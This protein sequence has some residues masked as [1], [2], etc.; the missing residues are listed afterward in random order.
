MVPTGYFFAAM[1]K[2]SVVPGGG[3]QQRSGRILLDRAGIP[4]AGFPRAG[5]LWIGLILATAIALPAAPKATRVKAAVDSPIPATAITTSASAPAR[6]DTT[7]MRKLYLEGDFDQAILILEAVL[8][9]AS[10]LS[11]QD[12]VFIFKHLGVMYAAKYD[13]REKGKY[14]MHQLLSVEPTVRILDMYASDMIYMI[15]KNI[16]DEYEEARGRLHRAESHVSGNSQPH[17]TDHPPMERQAPAKPAPS[18]SHGNHAIYWTG[19]AALT[20]AAGVTAYFLLADEPV[21][22]QRDHGVQ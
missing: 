10:N 7:A 1:I 5:H 18:S 8:K 6:L 16:Q 19:A 4:R 15:F 22:T 21:D 9:E 3:V 2:F 17:P 13:T 14:Y 11:R 12:S 20:V